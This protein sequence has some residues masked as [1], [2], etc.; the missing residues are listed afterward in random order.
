[1]KLDLV[2]IPLVLPGEVNSLDLLS[3]T[4]GRIPRPI[5]TDAEHRRVAKEYSIGDAEHC[6]LVHL[7]LLVRTRLAL[8]MWG[9]EVH[10]L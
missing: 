9:N 3:V 8:G 6:I 1:M 10:W 7:E 4:S 2:F 5:L